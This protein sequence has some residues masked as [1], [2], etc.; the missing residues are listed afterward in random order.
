MVVRDNSH[1]NSVSHGVGASNAGAGGIAGQAN[2]S[3]DIEEEIDF[4]SS[5]I[6][7]I[8]MPSL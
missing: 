2:N 1:L 5:E 7:L 4:E 8:K 3:A 6:D